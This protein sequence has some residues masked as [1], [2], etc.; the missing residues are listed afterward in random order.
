MGQIRKKDIPKK[1]KRG[2]SFSKHPPLT[3]GEVLVPFEKE[4]ETLKK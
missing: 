4:G 3:D 2:F 1:K